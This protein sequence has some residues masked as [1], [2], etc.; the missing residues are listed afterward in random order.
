MS[1]GAIDNNG[2]K[3]NKQ[4][5]TNNYIKISYWKMRSKLKLAHGRT[6]QE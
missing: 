2:I 4:P 6:Q 5:Y 3:P 1:S